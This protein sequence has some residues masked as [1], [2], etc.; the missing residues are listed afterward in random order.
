[1]WFHW[2]F[3]IK[4]PTCDWPCMWAHPTPAH[5]HIEWGMPPWP[6][7]WRSRYCTFLVRRAVAWVD[8]QWKLHNL[9]LEKSCAVQNGSHK[10]CT[11]FH[12]VRRNNFTA[13]SRTVQSQLF[14]NAKEVILL[15]TYTADAENAPKAFDHGVELEMT[16]TPILLL[17][18]V[19][20]KAPK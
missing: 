19:S 14:L 7:S 6:L 9:I 10:F 3:C 17:P 13:C 5:T 4:N 16:I 15:L 8:P 18:Q 12:H 1:M 11:S 2:A 20:I